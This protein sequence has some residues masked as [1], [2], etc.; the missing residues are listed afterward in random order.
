MAQE[1]ESDKE[2]ENYINFR[3]FT[4]FFKFPFFVNWFFFSS[5]KSVPELKLSF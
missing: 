4:H 3:L 2:L 1:K 5:E